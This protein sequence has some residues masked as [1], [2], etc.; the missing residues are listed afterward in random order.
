MECATSLL[1]TT[2]HKQHTHTHRRTDNDD[3][4]LRL[5]VEDVEFTPTRVAL[6]SRAA[7]T[8]CSWCLAIAK[9][10]NSH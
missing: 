7:G 1:I 5:A 2:S 3:D 4:L 6:H 9:A 10:G 8:L